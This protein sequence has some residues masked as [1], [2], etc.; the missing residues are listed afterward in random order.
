[1]GE[2]T[3][4]DILDIRYE[5]KGLAERAREESRRLQKMASSDDKVLGDSKEYWT[6]LAA[7]FD[8]K[9]AIYDDLWRAFPDWRQ[10]LSP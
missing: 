8:A 6:A 7:R 4:A 9:A 3:D 2:L 5:I 1:M 10:A